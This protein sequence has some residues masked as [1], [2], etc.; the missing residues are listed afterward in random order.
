[1]GWLKIKRRVSRSP[2]PKFF[3]RKIQELDRLKKPEEKGEI[4]IRYV[5]DV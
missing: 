1:M 2:L 3:D 5:D 4:E